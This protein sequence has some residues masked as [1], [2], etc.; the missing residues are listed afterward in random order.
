MHSLTPGLLRVRYEATAHQACRAVWAAAVLAKPT[1]D[2]P[3][4]CRRPLLSVIYKHVSSAL[5]IEERKT[6]ALVNG[7]VL[8]GTKNKIFGEGFYKTDTG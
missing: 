1:R 3:R 2:M 5:Q 6:Y 8:W 7:G 4:D